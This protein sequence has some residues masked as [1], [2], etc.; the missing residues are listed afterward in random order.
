MP[1]PSS[2]S[3]PFLR[4]RSAIYGIVHRPFAKVFMRTGGNTWLPHYMYLDSGADFSIVPS[5]IGEILGLARRP[6][7]RLRRAG[8]LGGTLEVAFRRVS[9]RIGAEEFE[10]EIGWSPNDDVPLLLGR[11]DVFNRFDVIIRERDLVTEFRWRG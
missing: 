1:Q 9:M 10:A 6:G 4:G 11:R 3:F 5:S 8:G 2:V 7:E